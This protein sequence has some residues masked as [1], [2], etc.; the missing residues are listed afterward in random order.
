MQW[1]I[2]AARVKRKNVFAS[3]IVKN[4]KKHHIKSKR[5]RPV[6]CERNHKSLKHKQ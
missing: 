5:K 3:W 1:K 6:A 4:A 2:Q